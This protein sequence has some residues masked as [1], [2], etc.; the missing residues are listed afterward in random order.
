NKCVGC[1]ECILICSKSA[2]DIQWDQNMSLFQKKMVEYTLAVLQGKRGR[3]AFMNFLTQISPACDCYGHN[4]APIVQDLGVMASTDPVAI[5][6]ASADMVNRQKALKHSCLSSH[7]EAD[8]DKFRGLYPQ[9][10]WT[11]QLDYAEKIGLGRRQYELINI[12]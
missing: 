5:D 6:Q 8:E 11:I 1:G 9:I 10:D 2:I 3:A 12:G 4:D 7:M